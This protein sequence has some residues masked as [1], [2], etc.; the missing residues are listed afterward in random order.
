MSPTYIGSAGARTLI[1][2]GIDTQHSLGQ[3]NR[4]I[5]QLLGHARASV[6]TDKTPN[7]AGKANETGQA[8]ARPAA[9]ITTR[10]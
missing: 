10:N 8:R 7:W 2:R 5:L 4:G 9:T 3:R 6:W 1:R